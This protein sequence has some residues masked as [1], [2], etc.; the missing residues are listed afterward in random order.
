M[1]NGREENTYKQATVIWKMLFTNK[2][3][4]IR[5]TTR[6]YASNHYLLEID[7]ASEGDIQES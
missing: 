6:L 3:D 7:L 1:G 2:V 5:L 4:F